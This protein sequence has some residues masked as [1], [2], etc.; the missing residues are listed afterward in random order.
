MCQAI[1]EILKN[2]VPL[3]LIGSNPGRVL[4]GAR[5]FLVLVMEKARTLQI[6]DDKQLP[7]S[8]SLKVLDLRSTFTMESMLNPVQTPFGL[9]EAGYYEALQQ[10]GIL[11]WKTGEEPLAVLELDERTRRVSLL[12]G[13]RVSEVT[14]LDLNILDTT[15]G[16]E[17]N[18]DVDGVIP[19]R[20][21]SDLQHLSAL[22]SRHGLSVLPPSRLS[23]AQAPVLTLDREGLLAVYVGRAPCSAPGKDINIFRPMRNGEQTIDVA[24][25]EQVCAGEDFH[26]LI[27]SSCRYPSPGTTSLSRSNS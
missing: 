20:E 14:L 12:S 2:V 27:L 10:G 1:Y 26:E 19:L 3:S 5:L 22:C 18:G 17:L 9:V 11:S 15:T 7:Y 16:Y 8:S 13:G 4:E 6:Q 23:S 25:V 24:I 21:M